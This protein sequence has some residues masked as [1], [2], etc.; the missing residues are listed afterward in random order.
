MRQILRHIAV[1]GEVRQQRHDAVLVAEHE[2]FERLGVV[3]AHA[4]HEPHVRI[5]GGVPCGSGIGD[6]QRGLF[7]GRRSFAGVGDDPARWLLMI[8]R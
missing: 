2:F 7:D 1:A 5:L 8:H 3:A 4:Q 6:G